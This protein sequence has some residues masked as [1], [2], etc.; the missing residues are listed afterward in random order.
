MSSGLNWRIT[1]DGEEAELGS[2]ELADR[3]RILRKV[4]NRAVTDGPITF[5]KDKY[6]KWTDEELDEEFGPGVHY[7]NALWSFDPNSGVIRV[8]AEKDSP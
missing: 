7:D 5:P 2:K 8:Q 1:I 4:S 6:D 3:A